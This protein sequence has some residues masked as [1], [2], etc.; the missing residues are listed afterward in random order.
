MSI[1]YFSFLIMGHCCILRFLFCLSLLCAYLNS[2]LAGFSFSTSIFMLTALMRRVKEGY[3]ISKLVRI[4]MT[5]T[6]EGAKL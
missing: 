2:R 6:K 4:H 1:L 3:S 5:T